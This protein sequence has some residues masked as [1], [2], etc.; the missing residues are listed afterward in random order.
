MRR[1]ELGIGLDARLLEERSEDLS[2]AS[3]S[4]L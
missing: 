4:L 2:K 1:V 3:D